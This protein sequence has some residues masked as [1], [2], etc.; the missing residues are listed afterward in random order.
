MLRRRVEELALPSSSALES[1]VRH[2]RGPRSRYPGERPAPATDAGSARNEAKA[3][4]SAAQSGACAVEGRSPSSSHP[5]FA[6]AQPLRSEADRRRRDLESMARRRSRTRRV[7]APRGVERAL[8]RTRPSRVVVGGSDAVRRLVGE[9]RGRVQS[10]TSAKRRVRV[11]R[12]ATVEVRT[13]P[14][15]SAETGKVQRRRGWVVRRA[16]FFCG[17]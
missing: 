11:R 12:G 6:P 9:P 4:S 8:A 7:A 16:E 17:R 2:A 3:G 15:E 13:D 14:D 10:R 5:P 1:F